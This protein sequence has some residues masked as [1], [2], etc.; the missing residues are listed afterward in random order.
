MISALAPAAATRLKTCCLADERS[1]LSLP[2]IRIAI[3]TGAYHAKIHVIRGG[4]GFAAS[5]SAARCPVCI[6]PSSR[7][8]PRLVYEKPVAWHFVGDGIAQAAVPDSLLGSA[9]S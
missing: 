2:A 9:Q 6:E 7:S 3:L 5:R 4:I 1:E 8:D